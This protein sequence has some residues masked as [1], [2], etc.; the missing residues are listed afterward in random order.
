M[1]K[2]TAGGHTIGIGNCNLVSSRIFNFTGKNNPSD[3]DPSLN[4][5]YAKF[6]Q[7]PIYLSSVS[8]P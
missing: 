5:P 2:H 3:I 7:V 8:I 4:P 1:C 6:L